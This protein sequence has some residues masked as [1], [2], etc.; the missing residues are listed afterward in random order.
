ML[1]K[2]VCYS[3]F[4]FFSTALEILGQVFFGISRD[5]WKT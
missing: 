5:G 1:L 4:V 2:L 3:M